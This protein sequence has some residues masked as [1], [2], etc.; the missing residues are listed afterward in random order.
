[1]V[2]ATSLNASSWTL[3]IDNP[4]ITFFHCEFTLSQ[5]SSQFSVICLLALKGLSRLGET[6]FKASINS[7][8]PKHFR[9]FF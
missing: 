4:P 9:P 2:L 3:E 6:Y 1:M 8:N 7:T 5:L